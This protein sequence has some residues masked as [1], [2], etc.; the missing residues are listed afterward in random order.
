MIR[1]Q[2]EENVGSYAWEIDSGGGKDERRGIERFANDVNIASVGILNSWPAHA[3]NDTHR[4]S[5]AHTY[6]LVQKSESPPLV[7]FSVFELD[8]VS[9]IKYRRPR[10]DQR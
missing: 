4:N 2:Q 1:G 8:D 6:I 10:P 5:I 3:N 9:A 7:C